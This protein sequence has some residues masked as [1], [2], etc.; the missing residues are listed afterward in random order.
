[1]QLT[2]LDLGGNELGTVPLCVTRLTRLQELNIHRNQIV[3]LPLQLTE[4]RDL[5]SLTVF[6]IHRTARIAHAQQY[7]HVLTQA[8]NPLSKQ[9]GHVI[10]AVLLHAPLLKDINV[11]LLRNH[12]PSTI[13]VE[14]ALRIEDFR[15]S[16]RS[17]SIESITWLEE[18][19]HTEVI[20][21]LRSQSPE[22]NE[23]VM[24]L[25]PYPVYE[26]LERHLFPIL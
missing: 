20:D 8:G 11:S 9:A 18:N 13:N 19:N 15:A 23:C 14:Q 26:E 7:V 10:M 2:H 3:D 24:E 12:H 6:S 16:D 25:L 21:L 5:R 22:L 1:M 17:D 4:L